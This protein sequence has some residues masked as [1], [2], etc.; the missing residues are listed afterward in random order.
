MATN[1]EEQFD[2]N[3]VKEEKVKLLA[4]TYRNGKSYSKKIKKLN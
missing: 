4:E 3:K 2:Y 1:S